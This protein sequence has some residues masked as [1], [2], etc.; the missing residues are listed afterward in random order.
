M[1]YFYFPNLSLPKVN[2]VHKKLYFKGS[3]RFTNVYFK[4]VHIRI[5]NTSIT[6]NAS[7]CAFLLKKSNTIRAKKRHQIL[8][9]TTKIVSTTFFDNFEVSYCYRDGYRLRVSDQLIDRLVVKH[10]IIFF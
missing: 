4:Y 7:K 6:S 8:T 3:F 10:I 1:F 2:A 9:L 5:C